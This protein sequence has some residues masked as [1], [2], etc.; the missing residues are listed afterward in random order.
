MHRRDDFLREITQEELLEKNGK[1]ISPRLKKNIVDIKNQLASA[2][3]TT[4]N[5]RLVRDTNDNV[6]VVGLEDFQ[7]SPP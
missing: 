6:F 4:P 2:G 7:L 1:S 5:L 3:L